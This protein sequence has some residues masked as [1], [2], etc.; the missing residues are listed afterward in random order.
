MENINDF[1]ERNNEL[2]TLLKNQD[3]VDFISYKE[4][5]WLQN[6]SLDARLTAVFGSVKNAIL[7]FK[8]DEI[9]NSENF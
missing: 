8:K 3:F 9:F 6:S 2:I 4:D 5:K 7:E 1:G